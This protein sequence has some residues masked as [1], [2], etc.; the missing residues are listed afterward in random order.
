MDILKQIYKNRIIVI[1]RDLQLEY[2]IR[3]VN[4]LYVGGIKIVEVTFN[5]AKPDM[6]MNTASAIKTIAEKFKDKV[7]VGA[8]TVLTIKQLNMA[9]SAGAQ[10]IVSPNVDVNIIQETKKLGLASFPGALT[11]TEVI[12]AKNA[13]ADIIK[14]FPSGNL[15]PSYIKAIKSPLSH[16]DFIA[17]GG[18]DE[19]N[20][21]NFIK[22]GAIGIGVGGNLVNKAW[23]EAGD[24]EK[25]T[26]LASDYVKA[27]EET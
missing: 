27:V 13:G 22:A 3:L 2:I 19:K 16:I 6:W 11:P 12:I 25:I 21:A 24:F 20:A 23:I 17:V 4:A 10:F 7:I 1:V 9:K 18:I 8:G 5:Q 26:M 14:I 15:G